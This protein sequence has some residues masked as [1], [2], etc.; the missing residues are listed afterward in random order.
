VVLIAIGWRPAALLMVL[1]AFS[2]LLP[3]DAVFMHLYLFFD[4][5]QEETNKIQVDVS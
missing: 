5:R 2:L 1:M 4:R 3:M